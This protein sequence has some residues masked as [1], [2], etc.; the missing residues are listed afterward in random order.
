MM[1]EL[2]VSQKKKNETARDLRKKN[3]RYKEARDT[4]KEKN[5]TKVN[6][7][8]KLRGAIDDLKVSR[9]IWKAQYQHATVENKKLVFEVRSQSQ[10]ISN[11]EKKYLGKRQATSRNSESV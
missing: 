6:D 9:D 2:V 8:K 11:S 7:I 10:S 3:K 4:L 5:K 1:N